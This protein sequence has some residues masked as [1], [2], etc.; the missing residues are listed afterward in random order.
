MKYGFCLINE[1][2][3][4]NYV[5]YVHG[6]YRAGVNFKPKLKQAHATNYYEKD[7]PQ[8]GKNAK[9]A[10]WRIVIGYISNRSWVPI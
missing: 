7:G 8:R 5:R 6:L 3:V 10:S 2:W 1:K 9:V 4:Q